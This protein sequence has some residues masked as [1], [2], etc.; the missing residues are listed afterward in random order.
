MECITNLQTLD[1]SVNPKTSCCIRIGPRYNKPCA[2]LNTI[3]GDISWANEMCYLGV[4]ISAGSKFRLNLN[5]NKS[6]FFRS[7]NGILAKIGN[8]AATTVSV[9]LIDSF[10]TPCLSY[11]LV[12]ASLTKTDIARLEHTYA[13]AFMKIF[14]TYDLSVVEQCQYYSGCLPF[15]E[16]VEL[17]KL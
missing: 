6:K 9:S 11:G 17:R 13:R 7:F 14:S 5:T 2:T 8:C 3:S 12:S 16:Q 15:S 4:L 10:C 1:M